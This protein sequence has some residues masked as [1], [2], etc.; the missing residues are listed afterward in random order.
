M[1]TRTRSHRRTHGQLFFF[2]LI[3]DLRPLPRF[4]CDLSV[5]V[6]SRTEQEITPSLRTA[7]EHVPIACPLGFVEHGLACGFTGVRLSTAGHMVK[8]VL[9]A[10]STLLTYR[11]ARFIISFPLS[12]SLCCVDLVEFGVTSSGSVTSSA[13]A[14]A[15]P[16]QLEFLS[17]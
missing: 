3:G 2:P 5:Q 1:K 11:A 12:L 9:V 10:K 15:I 6:L 16:Y 8:F 14:S 13:H 7:T 17:R 4:L